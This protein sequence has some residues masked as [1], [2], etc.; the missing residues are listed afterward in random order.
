MRFHGCLNWFSCVL[1]GPLTEGGILVIAGEWGS[2]RELGNTVVEVVECR[3][4]WETTLVVL[5]RV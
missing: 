2:L 4:V 3:G 1:R 5:R